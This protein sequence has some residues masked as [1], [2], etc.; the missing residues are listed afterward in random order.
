MSPTASHLLSDTQKKQWNFSSCIIDHARLLSSLPL[1]LVAP[2]FFSPQQIE[3]LETSVAGMNHCNLSME[4]RRA[5]GGLLGQQEGGVGLEICIGLGRTFARSNGYGSKLGSLESD[6]E[7]VSTR[8]GSEW[9][10]RVARAVCL[11]QY[12][13]DLMGNTIMSF[14]R[15]FGRDGQ[16]REDSS[17]WFLGLFFLY[18]VVAYVVMFIGSFC[19]TRIS[20]LPIHQRLRAI[21]YLVFYYLSIVFSASYIVPLGIIGILLY[22]FVPFA[23]PL[24][25]REEYSPI[26]SDTPPETFTT[27]VRKTNKEQKVGVRFGTSRSGSVMVTHIK[28]GGLIEAHTELAVGDTIYKINKTN[29]IG[30]TPKIAAQT[31]LEAVGEISIVASHDESVAYDDHTV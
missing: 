12:W 1:T 17:V 22:P 8:Q 6:I 28:E 30:K 31:L 5:M 14:F 23:E 21:L 15:G 19:I 27:V 16:F 26:H 10:S 18:Y 20:A 29:M 9:S 25:S 11:K 7:A 2:W 3:T 13:M 24:S 4:S